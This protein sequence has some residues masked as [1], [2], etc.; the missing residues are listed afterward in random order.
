LDAQNLKEQGAKLAGKRA[1]RS[2]NLFSSFVLQFKNN[3]ALNFVGLKKFISNTLSHTLLQNMDVE[4]IK[5][6]K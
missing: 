1:T 5:L 3:K 2:N 6:V 4:I